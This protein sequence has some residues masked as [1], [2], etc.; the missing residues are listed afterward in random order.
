MDNELKEALEIVLDFD[1]T[2]AIKL[3]VFCVIQTITLEYKNSLELAFN[4]VQN[5]SI[6]RYDIK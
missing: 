6:R 4:S 1:I 2:K 3:V 5:S